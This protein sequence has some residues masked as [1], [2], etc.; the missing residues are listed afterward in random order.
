MLTDYSPK[1]IKAYYKRQYREAR[2]Q[3][4]RWVHCGERNL[5]SKAESRY[6]YAMDEFEQKAWKSILNKIS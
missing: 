4:N 6:V 3:M 5:Y 1:A 2:E